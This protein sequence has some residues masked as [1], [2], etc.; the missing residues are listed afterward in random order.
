LLSLG[1]CVAVY[2]LI[3]IAV[4][5][6]YGPMQFVDF[7]E[8]K[9]EVLLVWTIVFLVLFS[10]IFSLKAGNDFSRASTL[11]FYV[12]GAG[13]LVA[14]RWIAAR[15]LNRCIAS[16]AFVRRKVIIVGELQEMMI[17]NVIDRLRRRGYL[18]EQV[19]YL[20][21]RD[22]TSVSFPSSPF[23]IIEKVIEASRHCGAE[24]IFLCL[25]WS[26]EKQIAK[27]VDALRVLPLPVRLLPDHNMVRIMGVRR[28]AACVKEL[29]RA[30]LSLTEQLTKRVMDVMI[31]GVALV[32]L[33][34]LMLVV[35][36]LIKLDSRG[37]VFFWQIRNGFNGREF[38]I[39][40]FRSMYVT[41]NGSEI[42]QATR[43]DSR[44]TRVGRWIRRTSIDELPQLLNVLRG[45]MSLVGP[46]PHA[47]A[48]NDQY[49]NLISTYV[50]R[51]HVKPGITG[52]AQLKGFRGETA[53]LEMMEN[54]VDHDIWYINNWSLWLDL[55]IIFQTAFIFAWQRSAY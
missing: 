53:A 36:A 27:I 47:A 8:Q 21:E 9:R 24:E 46:R 35:A 19:F 7:K 14:N 34:P 18:A 16:G 52:W 10:L 20:R 54:R 12:L 11:A 3:G 26:R 23:S 39:A 1:L 33:L 31:G 32:L 45:E 55:R 49:G 50:F 6:A 25:P 41:E 13:G 51:H 38:R 22:L 43:G 48:H 44:I 15:F 2:H 4:R 42:R 30:P 28:A 5:K 40:K 17:S 29:Q 37:P